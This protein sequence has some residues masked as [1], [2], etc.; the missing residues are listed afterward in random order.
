LWFQAANN[1]S[2]SSEDKNFK[3]ESLGQMDI[4]L[5]REFRMNILTWFLQLQDG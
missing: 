2:Y 1:F 5:S 3:Q 4:I